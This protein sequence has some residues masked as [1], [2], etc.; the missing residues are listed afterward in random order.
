MTHRSA[1]YIWED[2]ITDQSTITPTDPKDA[3]DWHLTRAVEAAVA[4]GIA[5]VD[6][7]R[8]LD[9]MYLSVTGIP[10]EDH[11]AVNAFLIASG[12]D[13]AADRT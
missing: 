5:E 9:F 1:E 11:P 8:S 4:A 7:I 3:I 13:R 12:K 6:L 2:D 10:A